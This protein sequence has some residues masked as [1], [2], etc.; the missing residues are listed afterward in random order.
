MTVETGK[1]RPPSKRRAAQHDDGDGRQQQRVAL[2]GRRFAG[3]AGQK[4][5]RQAVEQLRVDIGHH[6]M[7]AH[8]QPDGARSQRIGADRLESSSDDRLLQTK[9][10]TTKSAA[11][12]K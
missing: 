8:V 7:K 9:N 6:L 10:E 12:A 5:A 2:K 4:N 3:D 1:P 11:S